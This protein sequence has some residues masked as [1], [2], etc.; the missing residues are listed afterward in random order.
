MAH[1]IQD[2]RHRI[3]R[4]RRPWWSVLYGS[5]NPR[6]RSPARRLDDSS[7]HSL[8]WHSSHLL[9][10]AIGI[11]LLCMAD[12][13]MTVVLLQGGAH[14]VNPIM[15]GLIYRS[16]ALFAAFKMGLT[17]A[18]TVLMVFLARYRFLRVLRVEWVLYAVLV[19]YASLITYEFW[20]LKA[21][22]NLPI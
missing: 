10:V 3:D 8:D 2:R 16:V 22:V 5:F 15:A 19:A 4:R 20:M 9:A 17:S 1:T 12:A 13:F 7:F 18:G 21:S 6:R 11:L 14:E